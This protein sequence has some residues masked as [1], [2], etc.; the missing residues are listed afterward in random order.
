MSFEKAE[1]EGKGLA[2]GRWGGGVGMVIQGDVGV[3]STGKGTLTA[4]GKGE[5]RGAF[6]H[7]AI[8]FGAWCGERLC[9]VFMS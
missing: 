7:L 6:P 5:R 9:E 2:L 3:P 4:Q 8:W 1:K